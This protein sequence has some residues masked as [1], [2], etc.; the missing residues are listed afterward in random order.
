MVNGRRHKSYR[1]M[2]SVEAMAAGSAS[3]YGQDGQE[4]SAKLVPEGVLGLVPAVGALEDLLYQFCGGIK[5]GLG[6]IGAA[7]LLELRQRARWVRQSSNSFRES[8]P[9]SLEEVK[10]SPN[11]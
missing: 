3:R 11:Y 5:S 1:G 9:H 6:Y 4:D 7:N 2:G 8:H 10:A